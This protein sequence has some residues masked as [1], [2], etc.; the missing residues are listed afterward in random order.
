MINSCVPRAKATQV[1]FVKRIIV[2]VYKGQSSRIPTEQASFVSIYVVQN[3]RFP[4][5]IKHGLW[6]ADCNYFVTMCCNYTF[7]SMLT[8]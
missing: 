6:K 2:L 4:V 3:R 1:V 5:S 8:L 7:L